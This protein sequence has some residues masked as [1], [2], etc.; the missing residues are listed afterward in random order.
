ML[1]LLVVGSLFCSLGAGDSASDGSILPP[2]AQAQE[3]MGL[4]PS[5]AMVEESSVNRGGRQ[6]APVNPGETLEVGEEEGRARPNEEAGKAAQHEEKKSFL[7]SFLEDDFGD[8]PSSFASIGTRRNKERVPT[9]SKMPIKSDGTSRREAEG[10]PVHVEAAALDLSDSSLDLTGEF[11]KTMLEVCF[12]YNEVFEKQ[13]N[14]IYQEAVIDCPKSLDE[15]TK[16]TLEE[17]TQY[18]QTQEARKDIEM[19]KKVAMAMN[20]LLQLKAKKRLSSDFKFVLHRASMPFASH[21]V[22]VPLDNEAVSIPGE[23]IELPDF[24]P[25][26]ANS[27]DMMSREEYENSLVGYYDALQNLKD[28]L[29]KRFQF[30][31]VEEMGR[32]LTEVRAS[33]YATMDSIWKLDSE[34]ATQIIKSMKGSLQLKKMEQVQSP[35][36]TTPADGGGGFLEEGQEEALRPERASGARAAAAAFLQLAEQERLTQRA[37]PRGAGSEP[38]KDPWLPGTTLRSFVTDQLTRWRD[39]FGTDEEYAQSLQLVREA[40]TDEALLSACTEMKDPL[41]V[42]QM[43]PPSGRNKKAVDVNPTLQKLLTDYIQSHPDGVLPENPHEQKQFSKHVALFA[44]LLSS[45]SVQA[46]ELESIKEKYGGGI[47]SG[48]LIKQLI[49]EKLDFDDLVSALPRLGADYAETP[50]LEAIESEMYWWLHNTKTRMLMYEELYE[51]YLRK[52]IEFSV[53]NPSRTWK[54]RLPDDDAEEEYTPLAFQL[55][56]CFPDKEGTELAHTRLSYVR[57]DG[58]CGVEDLPD[59]AEKMELEDGVGRVDILTDDVQRDMCSRGKGREEFPEGARFSEK[60]VDSA[61]G[62]DV[63]EAA[64]VNE[65]A[66]LC[67]PFCSAQCEMDSLFTKQDVPPLFAEESAF[68]IRFLRDPRFSRFVKSVFNEHLGHSI[69]VD[70]NGPKPGETDKAIAKVEALLKQ[71]REAYLENAKKHGCRAFDELNSIGK[72]GDGDPG[73]LD[74][75]ALRAAMELCFDLRV[76]YDQMVAYMVRLHATIFRTATQQDGAGAFRGDVQGGTAAAP[77]NDVDRFSDFSFDDDGEVDTNG[78]GGAD[79]VAVLSSSR[80]QATF[81]NSVSAAAVCSCLP[82]GQL[83]ARAQQQGVE[84]EREEA[85]QSE[86]D[87]APAAESEETEREEEIVLPD[88]P[89]D[90]SLFGANLLKSDSGTAVAGLLARESGPTSSREEKGVQVA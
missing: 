7:D 28:G 87:A 8:S 18:D 37:V 84:S 63:E 82:A 65:F 11:H 14:K 44:I 72:V 78:M 5:V 46:H 43:I 9:T 50:N 71:H 58:F 66:V 2:V 49:Q 4:D 48:T 76:S 70:A 20:M 19:E 10:R 33:M 21:W 39:H 88:I 51:D 31:Q 35:P 15:W 57:S 85:K 73:A 59:S 25:V 22:A 32:S 52:T 68:D 79:P 1:R 17:W 34:K 30:S 40:V 81:F 83:E 67:E 89:D 54:S 27:G 75:E 56:P 12:Q 16:K 24:A 77:T 86:Q 13:S 80:V 29:E 55:C 45:D 36:Q 42:F 47:D 69:L 23:K 38:Q 3:L 41:M 90:D 61:D 62:D 64:V 60:L 6:A 74:P 53:N 26:H